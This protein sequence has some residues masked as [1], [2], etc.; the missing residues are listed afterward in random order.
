MP[1]AASDETAPPGQASTVTVP[2]VPEQLAQAVA[3]EVNRL[4][5]ERDLS[6]NALATSSGLP[7]STLAKRLAGTGTL[8]LDDVEAVCQALDIDIRDLIAWTQD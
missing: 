2:D 8:D 4:R 6:V 7:Q 5:T 1:D 3:R